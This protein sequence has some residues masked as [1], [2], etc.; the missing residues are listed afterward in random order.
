MF[1]LKLKQKG[2]EIL[3]FV[4]NESR[5]EIVNDIEDLPISSSVSKVWELLLLDTSG[6]CRAVYSSLFVLL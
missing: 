6:C 2:F 5:I 1:L 3:Y 4:C